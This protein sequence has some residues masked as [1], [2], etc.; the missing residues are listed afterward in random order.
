M[1]ISGRID[2]LIEHPYTFREAVLRNKI[3]ESKLRTIHSVTKPQ[4]LFLAISPKRPDAVKLAQLI[5][6]KTKE[7]EVSGEMR[8]LKEKYML[9]Y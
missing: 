2:L 9:S 8:K 7:L 5:A 1:L 4:D 3:P 6:D